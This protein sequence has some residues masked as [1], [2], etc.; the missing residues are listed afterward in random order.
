MSI[1]SITLL[2]NNKSDEVIPRL[3]QFDGVLK[4]PKAGTLPTITLLVQASPM[5]QS[6][7]VLGVDANVH[8]V[9]LAVDFP[10]LKKFL[11]IVFLLL[12]NGN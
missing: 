5:S 8:V 3:P 6:E 12:S 9:V 4:V 7:W 2:Q 11:M 10:T 1:D